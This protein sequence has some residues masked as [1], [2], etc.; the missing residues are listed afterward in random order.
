MTAAEPRSPLPP[1]VAPGPSL[2]SEELDRYSRHI[3]LPEIGVVGQRRLKNSRVLVVGAGGLGSPVLFYLAAAGVGTLGIIDD[4]HVEASN[5]QRQIIHS[6]ADVGRRKVDSARDTIGSINPLVRVRTHPH[7]LSADNAVQLF[8]QYDLIIDGA[9]NFATRYLV[10]DAAEL[11][12]KPCVWG[13]ILGFGA[14][15]SVFWS[16]TGPTYRDLY[17]DAPLPESAPSCGEAG[18]LGMLCGVAGS[19][20]AAEAVKL[21]TG[22]G[23]PL[24]GR[25]S[26]FD[27]GE[28]TWRELRLVRDIE[29]K[30]VTQL[31]PPQDGCGIADSAVLLPDSITVRELRDSL[32][33]R[34]AGRSSF[35]LIDVRER[36]EFEVV[37]IP[38]SR[39]M[40]L[41]R[42]RLLR[43]LE[44]IPRDSSIVLCCK[45]GARARVAAA[46]LRETDYSQVRVLLG[47]IE[48]WFAASTSDGSAPLLPSRRI[49]R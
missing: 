21:I 12:G 42:L 5:L 46:I 27:L 35:E 20:M 10:C 43:S 37:S 41:S 17:P 40:P 16:T 36:D 44:G 29:R 6:I 19:M 23:R 49:P 13:S 48:E 47:G 14:Q 3:L 32:G 22:T 18:V 8:E 9:D 15:V 38:G 4:D 24:L 26:I 39:S 30:P 11:T 25:L 33:E 28:A 31:A 7:R 2:E 45:V 34:S 1:L